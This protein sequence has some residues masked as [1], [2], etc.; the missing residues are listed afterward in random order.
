MTAHIHAETMLQYAQDAMKTNTPWEL[1]ECRKAN[2]N[3]PWCELETHPAWCEYSEYRHKPHTVNI[4]GYEVPEPVR[5]PL[6]IGTK[7]WS[8]YISVGAHAS[9]AT[10]TEHEFDYAR[11]RN[12]VI[13]QTSGAAIAHAK[14]LLSFTAKPESENE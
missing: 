7:Y 9:S 2:S 3:D 11:L 12:G 1:W 13:H 4:N 8:P 6:Y 5:S 14:A 10:W